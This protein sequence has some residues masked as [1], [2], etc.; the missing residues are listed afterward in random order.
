MYYVSAVTQKNKE[1]KA[2]KTKQEGWRGI[3]GR[4]AFP[5]YSVWFCRMC[6]TF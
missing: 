2:K 1:K 4:C 6:V 5:I 3:K